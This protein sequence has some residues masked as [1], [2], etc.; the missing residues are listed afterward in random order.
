[1]SEL[2]IGLQFFFSA[3]CLIMTYICTKFHDEIW[4]GF[5]VIEQTLGYK[6]TIRNKQRAIIVRTESKVTILF[7]CTSSDHALYLC[8]VS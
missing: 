5:E 7:L 4:N 1:M 6:L 8:K 3:H 2:K